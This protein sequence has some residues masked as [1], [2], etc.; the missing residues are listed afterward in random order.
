MF[1]KNIGYLLHLLVRPATHQANLSVRLVQHLL[2]L[3]NIRNHLHAIL[4]QTV[5]HCI[6]KSH[7]S[8]G[9]LHA[10]HTS[11]ITLISLALVETLRWRNHCPI[12][13]TSHKS[14]QLTIVLHILVFVLFAV[15]ISELV[16]IVAIPP[17][18]IGRNLILNN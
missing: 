7:L 12:V 3:S 6:T 15:V 5:N 8:L 2:T 11:L 13:V 14:I 18:F 16:C 1:T 17:K 9:G 10:T 4:A